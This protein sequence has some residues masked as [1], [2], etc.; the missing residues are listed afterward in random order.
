MGGISMGQSIKGDDSSMH[1][2]TVE[3]NGQLP[4]VRLTG[5]LELSVE[6]C[7]TEQLV[8]FFLFFFNF[9]LVTRR[10]RLQK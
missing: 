2:P 3:G 10:S 7:K 9:F 4:N 6:L 1:H 8:F 5:I